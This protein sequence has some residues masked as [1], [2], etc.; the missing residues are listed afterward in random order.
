MPRVILIYPGIGREPRRP[1][2]KSWLQEPL[3]MGVLAALTPSAWEVLFFDDRLEAIDYDCPADLAA[4]S[5]ETYSARRGYQIAAKFR[6]RN[7]SVVFGGFH[8]TFCPE[9]ALT[10][11]DAVCIGEAEGVWP[12]I[13]SDTLAG[14]LQRRYR[15]P[16]RP[17]LKNVRVERKLFD[18]K[19]YLP[20]A[21]V[22]TGRGCPFRCN[23]CAISAFYNATYRRRPVAEIVEEIGSCGRK[24]VFF[25][26]DNLTGDPAGAKELCAAVRPLGVKWITQA[27]LT[28]LRDPE[29]VRAMADAGCAGILI[30]FET[31]LPE[32]LTAM[33]KNTNRICEYRSIL[34]NLRRAGIFV[35]GTFVFGYPGDTPAVFDQSV[36]FASEEK[37]F[38]AAFNHL[39]PFPGTPLYRELEANGR[40]R[41]P[42][43][44]LDENFRFG[45]VP[46]NPCN[47]SATDLKRR[48]LKARKR[49]YG[50]SSI[51]RR[52]CDFQANAGDME[53]LARYFSLNL[54]LRKEVA[55]KFGIP[56]G[57]RDE[58][59]GGKQ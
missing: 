30:G 40:L 32:N 41:H 14:K 51:V 56:L 44:W 22:E 47:M 8:A 31:L 39:V 34:A 25:V 42:C 54:L 57:L 46:F 15:M 45:D 19:N 1:F 33:R 29:L 53:K 2:V 58:S 11:G 36:R 59:A 21:L 16:F 7:V 43:W 49:F 38:I 27:G 50:M 26:D 10:H 37:M 4:I 12:A 18:G 6:E 55:Q 20:L 35:Y 28:G 52:A 17:E 23:F 3:S 5:I 24:Y 13:L 48:C 9:E